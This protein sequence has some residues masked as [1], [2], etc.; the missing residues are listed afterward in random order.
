MRLVEGLE[1]LVL[2]GTLRVRGAQEPRGGGPLTLQGVDELSGVLAELGDGPSL[3]RVA[4]LIDVVDESTGTND[5]RGHGRHDH[6]QSELGPDRQVAEPA[7]R[8]TET[9]RDGGSPRLLLWLLAHVTAPQHPCHPLWVTAE[10][11]SARAGRTFEIPSRR[12][13]KEKAQVGS[14]WECG[15]M[16]MTFDCNVSSRSY[17]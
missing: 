3:I 15:G 11:S 7:A 16:F 14:D 8:P 17:P 12:V 6:D 4:G 9:R 10:H 13:S 1:E 2:L 5:D